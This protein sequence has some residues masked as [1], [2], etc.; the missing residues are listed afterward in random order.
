MCPQPATSSPLYSFELKCSEFKVVCLRED[1]LEDDLS[2]C[3]TPERAAEYYRK[4]IATSPS[5]SEDVETSYVLLLNTRHRPKGHTIV[6]TGTLDSL[7]LH[8]REVFRPAFV[9]ASAAIILF[10]NHPSGDPSPS[11]ADIKV[12]RDLIRAGQLLRIEILDHVVMGRSGSG[13]AKDYV[14]LKERGYFY[15]FDSADYHLTRSIP[16]KEKP[17][18]SADEVAFAD[19]V[20]AAQKWKGWSEMELARQVECYAKTIDAILSHRRRPSKKLH[21]RLQALVTE[22]TNFRTSQMPAQSPSVAA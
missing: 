6:A 8:P 7:F 3:D 14:S 12:T 10:H 22:Y 20:Q 16:E 13:R 18:L 4:H 21:A 2:A 17:S 5:F 15:G 19:L 11:E 1:R 9:S